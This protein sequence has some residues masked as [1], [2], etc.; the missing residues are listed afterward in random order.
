MTV[1][2]VQSLARYLEQH[3]GPNTAIFYDGLDNPGLQFTAVL[4]YHSPNEATAEGVAN[5]REHTV[6]YAPKM[7]VQWRYWLEGNGDWMAQEDFAERLQDHTED[8]TE[9][10]GAQLVEIARELIAK[11][12]F[13]FRSALNLKD[14]TVQFSYVENM[15]TAGGEK[16]QI[17]VPSRF[18][19][20]L[21]L[22]EG[23]ARYALDCRL[24][25]KIHER[26]LT[27]RYDL[28][29]VDELIRHV[30]G[31]LAAA[32]EQ[33]TKLEAFVGSYN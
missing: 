27:F 4:D 10:R 33:A 15:E 31:E 30:N 19:L 16:G 32:V 25:Y 21:P 3:G 6:R 1:R 7:S 12:S 29:K 17:E 11:K 20:A 14:G 22:H 5:W 8:V 2:D 28:L 26:R 13:D 24:R 23:G 18:T 9:P